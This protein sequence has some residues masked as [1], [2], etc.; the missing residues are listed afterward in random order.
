M[1]KSLQPHGLQHATLPYCSPSPGVCPSSCPL[2]QW[3]HP[4]ISS[5]VTLF[6]CLQSFPASVSFSMSWL[7]ESGGQSIGASAS[8]PPMNIQGWF[9]LE[10][11]GL[12]SLQST[13]SQRSSPNHSSKASIICCCISY[14]SCV[15]HG[16]KFSSLKE[17]LCIIS[18]LYKSEVGVGSRGFHS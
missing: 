2:H 14:L 3:C 15:T 6:S 5:S 11:T 17:H 18:Q 16:H 12:I 10:F 13:D 8:V 7:F 4:T 1:S 9:P